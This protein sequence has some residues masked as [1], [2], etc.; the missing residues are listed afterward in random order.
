MGGGDK[1]LIP[2][3]NRP[4][5]AYAIERLRRQV[6]DL[7]INANEDPARF[8][9]FGLPVIA[10]LIGGAKAR[11]PAF[12]R[13]S[14]GPAPIA[15]RPALSSPPPPTRRFFQPILSIAS[16]PHCKQANPS[17]WWQAP[18]KDCIRYSDYGPSRW[19]QRWSTRSRVGSGPS[20]PGSGTMAR[21]KCPAV[22]IGGRRLDPFFNLNR[23]EDFAEAET[24]LGSQAKRHA[25]G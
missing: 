20:A 17:C 9:H 15:P 7:V 23:P 10:D 13:E 8:A 16:S 18:M 21:K 25:D 14:N 3:G 1:S 11:L 12:M 22:E 5:L 4:L 24:I 19:R 6:A 2:L